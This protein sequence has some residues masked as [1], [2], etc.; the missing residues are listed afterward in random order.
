MEVNDEDNAFLDNFLH[1][2]DE[3]FD[4]TM[5][6]VEESIIHCPALIDCKNPT[7][8]TLTKSLYESKGIECFE[9]INNF[10]RLLR[11]NVIRQTIISWLLFYYS[12]A[13]FP[14]ETSISQNCNKVYDFFIRNDYKQHIIPIC[15]REGIKTCLEIMER[16]LYMLLQLPQHKR[17]D[18]PTKVLNLFI[19]HYNH[20][21]FH[22][23][24]FTN[25]EKCTKVIEIIRA[26]HNVVKHIK[27]RCYQKG[28]PTIELSN[29]LYKEIMFL[30][31]LS[32]QKIENKQIS[33][34]L[35]RLVPNWKHWHIVT[36]NDGS[37]MMEVSPLSK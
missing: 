7:L 27:E 22:D 15:E 16:L 30:R 33:Y 29:Q 9:I 25:S 26:S 6:F 37:R 28:Y 10:S 21:V 17:Q 1:M 8:F 36:L 23:K 20:T 14:K 34:N 4:T 5:D 35:D 3:E 18:I 31:E 2:L 13:V 32:Y 12:T 11:T 19:G 24:R